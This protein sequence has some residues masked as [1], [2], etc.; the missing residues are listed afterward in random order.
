MFIIIYTHRDNGTHTVTETKPNRPRMHLLQP[1]IAGTFLL[2][3]APVWIP[4]Y[5]ALSIYTHIC[6]H[7]WPDRSEEQLGMVLAWTA[8]PLTVP[9]AIISTI[10]ATLRKDHYHRIE[11]TNQIQAIDTR[12]AQ[13]ER[14]PQHLIRVKQLQIHRQALADQLT[15]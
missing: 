6:P 11:L 1:I 4:G 12:I 10:D 2:L 14:I 7:T 13:E 8:W 3:T 5:A 9:A 15:D